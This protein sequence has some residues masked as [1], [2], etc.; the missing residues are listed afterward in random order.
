MVLESANRLSRRQIAAHTPT[1]ALH[2]LT[3][4]CE[5]NV[6]NEAVMLREDSS[7]REVVVCVVEVDVVVVCTDSKRLTVGGELDLADVL[8]RV[9]PLVKCI[10]ISFVQNEERTIFLSSSKSSAST[11]PNGDLFAIRRVG[12]S[13]RHRIQFL[14]LDKLARRC[15]KHA[16]RLVIT[17]GTKLR[18]SWVHREAPELTFA[19]A[20]HQWACVE[21]RA[22]VGR[23]FEDLTAIGANQHTRTVGR[24]TNAA[25]PWIEAGAESSNVKFCRALQI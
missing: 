20:T 9:T 11:K 16:D 7:L 15:I 18:L 5:I 12:A 17:N 1:I 21:V 3:V 10:K 2:V 14:E 23:K 19:V 13:T 25:H 6:R 8:L 4:A 22:V 24:Q